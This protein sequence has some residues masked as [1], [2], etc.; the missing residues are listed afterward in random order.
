MSN[1]FIP[2]KNVTARELLCRRLKA[3]GVKVEEHRSFDERSYR[4]TD[5]SNYLW[6]F[7]TE[8]GSVSVFT[9][10]SANNPYKIL[11][12]ISEAFETD[13]FSESDPQFWGFG[14]EEEMTAACKKAAADDEE[15][16]DLNRH[17][18]YANV[19]AYV[20]GEP[21]N[22]NLPTKI[23]AQIARV[24]VENDAALLGPEMKEQ[25]LAEIEVIDAPEEVDVFRLGNDRFLELWAATMQNSSQPNET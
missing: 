14:T 11:R 23:K 25:L 2:S 10:Q 5:G 18:F 7:L 13:I 12:A 15:V 6:A 8:D 17:Q 1:D 3:F 16:A 21:N 24:L 19:C 20:R 4:L 9:A 22:I